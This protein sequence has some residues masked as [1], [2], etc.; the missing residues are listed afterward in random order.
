MLLGAP[1]QLVGP[2]GRLPPERLEVVVRG[3][4]DI[5]VSLAGDD[6]GLVGLGHDVA[7]VNL[8]PVHSVPDVLEAGLEGGRDLVLAVSGGLRGLG[9]QAGTSPAQPLLSLPG[10]GVQVREDG[11]QSGGQQLDVQFGGEG[12]G[13]GGGGYSDG[14]L[15]GDGDLR[16]LA[17]LCQLVQAD[18]AALLSVCWN[19]VVRSGDRWEANLG[20]VNDSQ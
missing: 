17:Q 6:L 15:V 12:G 4:G 1:H 8:P 18:L 14:S 9:G 20:P 10:G 3:E 16:Q 13:G 11:R 7:G 5:F 2:D 19:P